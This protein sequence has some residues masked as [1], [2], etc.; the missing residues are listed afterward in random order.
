[1]QAAL[2]QLAENY[3]SGLAKFEELLR[4]PT[5]G[6]EPAH[7]QDMTDCGAWLLAEMERI[8][9]RNCASMPTAG[10]PALYGEWL[11]A[12]P[13]AP[14]ALVYAHYDVQPVDP[15]SLWDSPPFEPARREGRLYA[16]GASDD[17][18]GIWG[19]LMALEAWLA[20]NGRLP[21]NIKFLFEGEEESGSPSMAEFVAAHKEKFSADLLVNSD[22][23]FY[24]ER[25]QIGYAYRGIIAAEITV[26]CA[27]ADLHSGQFGGLVH[28]PNHVLGQII[29][30]FHD[31]RG[32]IQID[33][34]YDDVEAID[35]EEQAH[36]QATYALRRAEFEAEAHTDHFWAEALAP[37][38]ERSTTLPSLD[39]N[40]IRGGYAGPGV[41]TVIPAQATGKVTMRIVPEQDP[42]RIVELFT[43]HI[44]QFASETAEVQVRIHS[45]SWP[46]RIQRDNAAMAAMQRA[47]QAT[48]GRRATLTRNGGS[49]PILGMLQR[50]LGMPMTTLSYSTGG[51]THAPNE[52]LDLP[53]FQTA[54][55]V[56]IRFYH[57]LGKLGP[58][59][60]RN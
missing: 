38:P 7:R 3:E 8:G 5:I 13:A 59:D 32:R 11:A 21:I 37:R 57:E 22:G 30:S 58:A 36:L 31:E 20:A 24:R 28:N 10:Q 51:N 27:R 53:E 2:A 52:Y 33:G 45:Q 15:L 49:I 48:I 50:E 12:G 9:F 42:Q 23:D 60:F 41:K 44:R 54:L 6:A 35:E 14:T 19:N 46:F 16:R 34:F 55:R 25:P 43:A 18:S 40:G 17:K 47:L 29:A 4:F 56:A 39:V 1:M 26:H